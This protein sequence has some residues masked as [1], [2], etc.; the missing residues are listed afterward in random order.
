MKMKL[1]IALAIAAIVLFCLVGWNSKAQSS[2]RDPW[3]HKVIT[4]YGSTVTMPVNMNELNNAGAEGWELVTVLSEG[5]VTR[6]T[7]KQ[8]KV[9]YFFKRRLN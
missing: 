5:E 6:G 8:I 1:K 9:S 4:Q 2:S 7:L 3:E